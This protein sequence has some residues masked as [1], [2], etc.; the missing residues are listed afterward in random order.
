MIGVVRW[1]PDGDDDN[2]VGVGEASTTAT[3]KEVDDVR[4]QQ[5]KYMAAGTLPL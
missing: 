5:R 1:K 3:E 2:D 4:R